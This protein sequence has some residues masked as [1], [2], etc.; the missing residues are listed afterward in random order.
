MQLSLVDAL[1]RF[2]LFQV[3]CTCVVLRSPLLEE[4]GP[5]SLVV[6]GV[7][8]SLAAS[9]NWDVWVSGV[10]S[11]LGEACTFR[12]PCPQH[13]FRGTYEQ[14]RTVFKLKQGHQCPPSRADCRTRGDGSA[15]AQVHPH[16]GCYWGGKVM[17]P[18][19]VWVVCAPS[20]CVRRC[21]LARYLAWSHPKS[22]AQ[23]SAGIKFTLHPWPLWLHGGLCAL[24]AVT[25][26]RPWATALGWC[27]SLVIVIA[28][29]LQD[30]TGSRRTPS[31][32]SSSLK[33]YGGPSSFLANQ[34]EL[35]LVSLPCGP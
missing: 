18:T 9:L 5:L 19:V 26:Q 16:S 12:S 11:Q 15:V 14:L 28:L 8:L 25:W 23:L 22:S 13:H 2:S 3:K 32:S 35:A 21:H 31:S 4:E 27:V 10:T 24:A 29:P 20:G 17:P 33:I 6:C 34:A 7:S 30:V 1:P